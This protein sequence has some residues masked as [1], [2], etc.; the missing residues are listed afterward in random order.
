MILLMG[1]L[2]H[3]LIGDTY[4]L[5]TIGL[6]S[7]A[8][9][10]QFAPALLIGL[11]WRGATRQGAAAALVAGFIVWFYT[12]LLPGFAQ[13]GWLDGTLITQG[14]WGLAWL[15]P[16]ALLGLT[17][18]DIYTHSLFWS[19]LCNVGLLVGVSLF[20]RP[21][22]LEQTQAALFTGA[23]HPGLH[24]TSLWRGE[25]TE[26]ALHALLIRY[27]GSTA[28]ERVFTRHGPLNKT[29]PAS[30]GLITRAEQALAGSLGSASASV[31]INSVLRGEA[32]DVASVLSILDT[33]SQT[34]E[35]NRRLE[36]KSQELARVGQELRSANER[37]R[38]LDRMKDE[39]VAMVSHELRTPLTSIRSFAEILRDT[40][41][42]SDDKRHQFLAIM[43]QESERLSRLIEEILDL[44][45]LE[46]GRLTMSPKPIDL[47]ALARQSSD[48][49]A[50]LHQ[51]EALT[52]EL[53]VQPETAMVE[54]DP[55]R[56]E[57]VIINLLE[58]ARKFAH[59]THPEIML[60]VEAYE[61]HFRLS[62]DDNGPG[63]PE[64]EREHVF[65]KFYQLQRNGHSSPQRPKGSGL[66]LPI[67]RAIVQHLGGKLWAEASP[68]GGTRM[69]IELPT[70]TFK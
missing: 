41:D 23:M 21:T 22:P 39:F 11:Y 27:L 14:P 5:V 49:L 9:V 47:V 54:A 45:R 32:L 19:M 20:T 15:S 37:L 6:V 62:V 44:A 12:L 42:I 60:S 26:G 52:F 57:Q 65:E 28:T 48:A 4:S 56:L 35:Y 43:V 1:Y 8:G 70:L 69:S 2:Y 46:S 18:W 68:L 38:E 53:V 16:Y 36:Q 63:I 40:P 50:R 61:D 31:L 33:T 67:S 55:D 64:E 51:E 59:H 29:Q 13:S 10:A 30:S 24:T 58:N 7:F 34:L 3:A 66:G 25:T 17:G